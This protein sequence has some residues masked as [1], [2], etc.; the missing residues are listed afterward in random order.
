MPPSNKIAPCVSL[1]TWIP[2]AETI[3]AI[4]YFPGFE[5]C[6]LEIELIRRV[7]Y[8]A[9]NEATVEGY[10]TVCRWDPTRRH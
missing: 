2:D 10:G 9:I 4:V 8:K 7:F 5:S 6:A 1:T 3:A